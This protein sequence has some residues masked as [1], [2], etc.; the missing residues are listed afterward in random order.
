ME[1]TF[2]F[3]A[4]SGIKAGQK[5]ATSTPILAAKGA[6]NK[7]T[8]N[9]P[10]LDLMGVTENNIYFLCNPNAPLKDRYMVAILPSFPEGETAIGAKIV[11]KE[12]EGNFGATFQYSPVWGQIMGDTMEVRSPQ[13]MKLEG[14]LIPYGKSF[15]SSKQIEFV[16]E[17]VADNIAFE[18]LA[19]WNTELE[20]LQGTTSLF[21]LTNPTELPYE[22]RS[23]SRRATNMDLTT[24]LDDEVLDSIED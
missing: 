13:E 7:F 6:I 9:K 16:L 24:D 1:T 2:N 17:K 12:E 11:T 21:K 20:G 3:E 10:A 4:F 8:I 19:Q 23:I 22:K 15:A 18:Q 14:V 5:T